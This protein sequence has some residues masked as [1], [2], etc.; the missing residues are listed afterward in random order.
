MTARNCAIKILQ[1][2]L[3]LVVLVE[4]G[5]LALGPNRMHGFA[6][7]GLPHWLRPALAW[8][9]IIGAI[10]FLIP[11]TSTFGARLLLVVFA[12][13]A[14]VHLIH[15]QYNIGSLLV[16]AAAAWVVDSDRTRTTPVTE[17]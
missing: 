15:G 6:G 16:Y 14:I 2:T 3:G 5:L 9:E 1:W 4:A 12:L 10:L 8:P 7:T 17:H 13:A 11:A